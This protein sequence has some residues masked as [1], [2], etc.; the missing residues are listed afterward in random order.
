MEFYQEYPSEASR[1]QLSF[2][3]VFILYNSTR[4]RTLRVEFPSRKLI[5]NGT[6][7]ATRGKLENLSQVDPLISFSPTSE[8][9]RMQEF[10]RTIAVRHNFTYVQPTE[11][12]SVLFG[13]IQA[14]QK[15]SFSMHRSI[16]TYYIL[17][18][19]NRQRPIGYLLIDPFD[20]PTW[21]WVL[22]TIFTVLLLLWIV[23]RPQF[24]LS[25]TILELVQIIIN[26][27]HERSRSTAHRF[28][29]SVFITGSFI[30]TSSYESLLTATISRPSLYP[31]LDNLDLINSSCNPMSR[32]D[33]FDTSFKFMYETSTV[34]EVDLKP[35]CF[36]G[37]NEMVKV[38]L[39]I[40][41]KDP[42][43]SPLSYAISPVKMIPFP[44][45]GYLVSA[46]HQ[47]LMELFQF[48]ATAFAQAGLPHLIDDGH[49]P[50][51]LKLLRNL[52]TLSY[53]ELLLVW[54]LAAFGWI[55]SLVV[56]C[57]ELLWFQSQSCRGKLRKC[58]TW[59]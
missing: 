3:T 1:K 47:S 50:D 57:V 14:I 2:N 31:P 46:Y 34:G 33:S 51:K 11:I 39:E 54:K 13:L 23:D 17:V 25:R 58:F 52:K 28:I 49:H 37:S 35:G 9:R 36:I 8:A 15:T 22:L 53:G 18:P 43:Y 6:S 21:I 27:P 38:M 56:F 32:L 24:N 42:E 44:A 7:V 10:W 30:L 29:I 4:Y 19:T 5:I 55:L 20:L 12:F 41:R 26:N 40:C 45:M 48:Y 16:S 59:T